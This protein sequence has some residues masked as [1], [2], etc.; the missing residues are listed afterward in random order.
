MFTKILLSVRMLR[1]HFSL[2]SR[3]LKYTK[4]TEVIVLGKFPCFI[5]VRHCRIVFPS[6]IPPKLRIQ[7]IEDIQ[8]DRTA[9]DEGHLIPLSEEQIQ[10]LDEEETDVVEG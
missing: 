6:R 1:F 5:L 3:S 8:F 7:S 10:S 2:L 9:L 4:K